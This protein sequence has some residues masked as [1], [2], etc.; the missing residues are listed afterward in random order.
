MAARDRR[1]SRDGRLNDGRR[2]QLLK[3]SVSFITSQR[4]HFDARNLSMMPFAFLPTLVA[5]S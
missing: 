1:G 4:I 2:W 5:G 3:P